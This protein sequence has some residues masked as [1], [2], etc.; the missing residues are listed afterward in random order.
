MDSLHS[1]RKSWLCNSNG[2]TE[3]IKRTYRGAERLTKFKKEQ[4]HTCSNEPQSSKNQNTEKPV[5]A[6]RKV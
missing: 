6:S 2:Q 5:N 4:P 1:R 3:A